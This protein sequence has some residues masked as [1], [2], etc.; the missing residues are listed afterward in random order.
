MYGDDIL[1]IP[2]FCLLECTNVLWKEVRFQ[3]LPQANAQ[4]IVQEL[5]RLPFQIEFV[6][7]LLP[8]TL[9]QKLSFC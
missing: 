5:L 1:H 3:R 9:L 6:S 7:Q 2:E 8:F 4:Q